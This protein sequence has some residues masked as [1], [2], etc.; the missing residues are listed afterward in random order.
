VTTAEFSLFFATL[1]LACWVG[2]LATLTV[3][4]GRARFGWP[5]AA[6]LV[7]A[8]SDSALW[9]AW[10]VATVA[11][12]G[13]L[14]YSLVA[15]FDPC[16]LCWYQRICMYPL[17]AVLLVA[18]ARGDR[19]VWRYAVPQAAV[20]AVI[21]VYHTQL[22]AFPKQATFCRAFNPCTTRFVWEFGFVSLPF[23][24]LAA[25]CLVITL[26]LVAGMVRS[27]EPPADLLLDPPPGQP[28]P[29]PVQESIR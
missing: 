8:I 20:G 12:C 14:Y 4:A 27:P 6:A 15:H 18:A 1:S 13:S 19:Q 29:S 17:S 2:T 24:A 7:Q 9:L 23:M 16:E 25:F 10:L 21:A 22:Q 5:G 26:V 28:D 3:V 11:T